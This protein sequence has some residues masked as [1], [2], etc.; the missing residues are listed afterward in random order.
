MKKNSFLWLFA[1][2]PF[3]YFFKIGKTEPIIENS[4]I[5]ITLHAGAPLWECKEKATGRIFTI[6][7]P[8]FEIDKIQ[9]ECTLN[10]LDQAGEPKKLK[11]GVTEYTFEGAYKSKPDIK[12]RILCRISD[13]N[14]VVRF[15]YELVST[16]SHRMTK[17]NGKDNITYLSASF[18]GFPEAKE[19]G[20]SDFNEMAHSYCLSEKVLEQKHFNNSLNVMGPIMEATDNKNSLLVAYEHGSQ[21]PNVFLNYQ[22][23]PDKSVKLTAVKGNYY[24]NQIIDATHTYQTIWFEM[25][26]TKGGEEI[27][28]KEYR[29][30]VLHYISGNLESRKPYI[31]YNTWN[32]QERNKNWYKR[33]YLADMTEE[34]MMK[35]IEAAHRMGIEVFVIDAGWFERTGDWNPSETRFPD[36]FKTIKLMLDRYNMKLGLWFNPAAA[37]KSSR[38]LQKHSDC[39]KTWNGNNGNH[40]PV[41]ETEDSYEMCLVSRYRDAF[42]DELIRL[43][44]TYGVTYFKWD[45]LDQSGCNDPRHL[46]GD[47]QCGE[48]ERADCFG[49]ELVRSM[50]Y[51]VDKLCNACPDAIVDFDITEAGRCVGLGFL[52]SGKYFLLNNGP[53]FPN[54]NIPF[55]EKTMNINIFFYPGAAR[56]WI[57][58]TPLTYDKWIPSVLFLTH[59]LP[60]DSIANQSISVGSLILGQNGIWG[61]LPKVSGEGIEFISKT[62]GLYKQVRNDMTEASMIREG[63]VSTDP[64]IYEKI[65][66]ANGKGAVVIFSN[67][68]GKYSYI[69][70]NKPNKQTWS[71]GGAKVTFDKDGY[72]KI[73][74]EFVYG[75]IEAKI[76][77][78]GVKE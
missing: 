9:L 48:Q 42:A 40:W 23:S 2:V 11:N 47:E 6:V 30:F 38:M 65:N 75:K 59:Y 53:Y 52:S 4:K 39:V 73:D 16:A 49:F 20:L 5:K 33:P 29:S 74:A 71:T 63:A 64:E 66:P 10:S 76:I 69:T 19:I 60:D 54:Y 70:K 18:T 62:L 36:K 25:A 32:F 12:L 67:H 61:D 41:W 27:L 35:E 17:K 37:G 58:R 7:G 34:R 68:H 46:H 51:V 8:S 13:T 56:G 15:C 72:A 3:F 1:I 43:N 50:S 77:Y 14:S 26:L 24:D 78:F 22:L 21:V 31:F 55:N 45:A 28:S 44:K 57:C